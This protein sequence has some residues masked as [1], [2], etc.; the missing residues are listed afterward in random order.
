MRLLPLAFIVAGLA[1]A[2]L[3]QAGASPDIDDNLLAIRATSTTTSTTPPTS[4]YTPTVAP[5]GVQ[6]AP[7]II[8][9]HTIAV[10]ATGFSFS[11]NNLT[12]AAVGSIIEFNFYPGNHSVVRSAYKFPCIPY[13]DSGPNR[14]GFFSGYMDTNV[15]SSDGPK[16]R[17]RINDTEPIF[18]YCSAPGSCIKHGMLGVINPNSTWTL[19]VQEEYAANTT[20]QLA[21][22]DPL[23]S[24][25]APTT[26]GGP[27]ATGSSSS[28]S[29]SNLS[30]GVIAG[31]VIGSIAGIIALVG[32]G[33]LFLCCARRRNSRWQ[34]E[35]HRRL[36]GGHHNGGVTDGMGNPL[37][38]LSPTARHVS[39][40]GPG[41]VLGT[42]TMG[43]MNAYFTQVD[44]RHRTPLPILG[45][46]HQQQNP[47]SGHQM[48]P[49]GQHMQFHRP[50]PYGQPSYSP[51]PVTNTQNNLPI[52]NSMATMSPLQTHPT[53]T[54]NGTMMS[55]TYSSVVA[56]QRSPS[57]FTDKDY[58]RTPPLPT[59]TP[60]HNVQYQQHQQHQ[61]HQ[62][63]PAPVE[64]PGAAATSASPSTTGCLRPPPPA[65]A[66]VV[67][68]ESP[69]IRGVDRTWTKKEDEAE[70]T[71]L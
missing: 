23:P 13:E 24:E 1:M 18:Y 2:G 63:Q 56:H 59:P 69:T 46:L 67:R 36:N 61:Q 44:Y 42:S 66:I 29:S 14:V 60:P 9:T 4:T 34:Q 48:T 53:N 20:I 37:S 6:A 31:I 38:P 41:V 68:M 43:D 22:G 26:A 49:T 65:P 15:Y 30:S 54:L 25:M 55:G 12:N 32:L 11:P 27:G 33:I 40:P 17:V 62:Q 3:V 21:P 35:R 71:Q 10:G 47:Y 16:F 5:G 58:Y 64:L 28:K 45:Q 70:L 57:P 51:L 8:P 52:Y 39:S 50:Y 19:E 7:S